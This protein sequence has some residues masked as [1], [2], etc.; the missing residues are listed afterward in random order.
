MCKRADVLLS[1]NEEDNKILE[2]LLGRVED[3]IVINRRIRGRQLWSD[4][5]ELPFIKTDEGDNY[6]GLERARDFVDRELARK[7]YS[8]AVYP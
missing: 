5:S 7:G 1:T 4:P 3:F 2:E 6:Y 8:G